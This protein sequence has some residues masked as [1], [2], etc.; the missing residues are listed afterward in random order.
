M[1]ELIFTTCKCNFKRTQ[2][3]II[4]FFYS[5]MCE[6][7]KVFYNQ[8]DMILRKYIKNI[9]QFNITYKVNIILQLLVIKCIT[10]IIHIIEI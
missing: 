1:I 3:Y 7:Y 2:N 8:A 6:R 5:I 9:N 10:E 4:F